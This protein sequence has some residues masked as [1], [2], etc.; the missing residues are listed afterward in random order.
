MHIYIH[1]YIYVYMFVHLCCVYVIDKCVF[2]CL[3][4]VS[5]VLRIFQMLGEVCFPLGRAPIITIPKEG[6]W[7]WYSD[8]SPIDLL[9]KR[10]G[11]KLNALAF[12]PPDQLRTLMGA[13]PA[14]A[15]KVRDII[16]EEPQ[17][18][19]PLREH[20]PEFFDARRKDGV[21]VE[22]LHDALNEVEFKDQIGPLT[23]A[24]TKN[25]QTMVI[26]SR[27][28]VPRA[29]DVP[30]IVPGEDAEEKVFLFKPQ[31]GP[32]RIV[33]SFITLDGLSYTQR[34][35]NSNQ[36][37]AGQ[38]DLVR[39]HHLNEQFIAQRMPTA[40]ST[41]T[42]ADHRAK[43]G[44]A[45]AVAEPNF[46]SPSPS[47]VPLCKAP[48]AQLPGDDIGTGLV[49]SKAAPKIHGL[50]LLYQPVVP[51]VNDHRQGLLFSI[52]LHK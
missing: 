14:F 17:T 26:P 19:H 23:M 48:A 31:Q 22:Y 36:V 27:P 43:L 39:R 16:N 50:G 18:M 52:F 49:I 2:W 44:L 11:V 37:L 8:S 25:L 13:N 41:T 4:C 20:F 6:D 21:S 47:K 24:N 33:R 35:G 12:I 42:I 51:L 34:L 1:A 5:H 40:L 15:Q 9:C 29:G 7:A 38:H 30:G 45:N 28:P 3:L 10:C 46:V 32:H